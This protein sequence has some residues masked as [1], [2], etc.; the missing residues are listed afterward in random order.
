MAVTDIEW[1]KWYV[2][3]LLQKPIAES[4]M[5]DK[6]EKIK[7]TGSCEALLTPKLNNEV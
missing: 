1:P 5:K 4:A 3:K 2:S 6:L 7:R